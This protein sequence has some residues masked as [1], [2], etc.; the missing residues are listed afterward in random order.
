MFSNII[1]NFGHQIK[2]RER[3]ISAHNVELEGITIYFIINNLSFMKYEIKRISFP[4]QPLN[5]SRSIFITST[6]LPDQ[7]RLISFMISFQPK[8]KKYFSMKTWRGQQ[9]RD[10]HQYLATKPLFELVCHSAIIV[11]FLL[12]TEETEVF[13]TTNSRI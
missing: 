4:F 6:N 11:K 7:K 2:I 9:Y 12:Q 10:A 1:L 5:K 8:L 3:F 13:T